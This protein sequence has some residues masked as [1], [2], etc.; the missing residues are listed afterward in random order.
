MIFLQDS[1]VK[2]NYVLFIRL[3]CPSDEC[4]SLLI[5]RTM[6]YRGVMNERKILRASR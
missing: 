1:T 4:G 2:V 3:H 6:R 5:M